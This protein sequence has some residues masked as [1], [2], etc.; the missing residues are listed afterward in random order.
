MDT[1]MAAGVDAVKSDPAHVAAAAL[2]GVEA[3]VAEVLGD[4]QTRA[5]KASLSA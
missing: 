3:G 1:D 2:D 5:V 4:E